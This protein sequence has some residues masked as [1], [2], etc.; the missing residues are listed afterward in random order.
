MYY[1]FG[2]Q[3]TLTVKRSAFNE[4]IL[5]IAEVYRGT[6]EHNDLAWTPTDPEVL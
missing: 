6:R 4:T 2:V 5:G 3:D 1:K